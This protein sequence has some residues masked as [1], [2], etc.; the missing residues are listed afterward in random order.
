MLILT[1]D[2]VS[3]V[4]VRDLF[5]LNVLCQVI[6]EMEELRSSYI[7]LKPA[8]SETRT[9]LKPTCVGLD[10]ETHGTGLAGRDEF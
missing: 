3:P 2:S 4:Y 9:I 7:Y 6:L 8:P 5:D 10:F 1:Q